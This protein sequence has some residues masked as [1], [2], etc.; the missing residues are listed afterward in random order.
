MKFFD[1]YFAGKT[2]CLISYFFLASQGGFY[3]L[4]FGKVLKVLSTESFLQIRKATEMFIDTPLKTLYPVTNLCLLI[5]VVFAEKDDGLRFTLLLMS[6]MLLV[7]DLMLAV[8]ISIP[9]NKQIARLES[10][11]TA[12]AF[13]AKEKWIRFIII[14]G[15]LSVTGFIF[16][17]IRLLI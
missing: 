4:A 2:C 5:W 3:L 13:T 10:S 16:L 6:F 9:L 11:F 8:K 17:L 15:Y 12:E 14:R 7:L 1:I